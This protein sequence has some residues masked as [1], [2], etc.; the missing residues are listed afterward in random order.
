[1]V[2]AEVLRIINT[3]DL[4]TY[5]KLLG[6]RVSMQDAQMTPGLQARAWPGSQTPGAVRGASL[7][8][9]LGRA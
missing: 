1:M 5:G 8:W 7:R 3:V 6:V 9:A 2:V 4:P